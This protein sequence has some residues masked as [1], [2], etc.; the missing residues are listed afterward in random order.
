MISSSEEKIIEQNSRFNDVLSKKYDWFVEWKATLN[1]KNECFQYI[2]NSPEFDKA[3]VDFQYEKT[4]V[5][6]IRIEEFQFKLKENIEL[7][8]EFI[9]RNPNQ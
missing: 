9:D 4:F 7:L 8:E 2:T 5:Y 3:L 6:R 1:C